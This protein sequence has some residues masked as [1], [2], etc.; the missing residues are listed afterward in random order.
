M[1]KLVLVSALTLGSFA[2]FAATP[3]IFH[4]GIAEDIYMVQEEY[5]EIEVAEV[6]QAITDALAADFPGAEISKAYKNE[7]SEYKLEVT[8]GEE[9][10]TLYANESGEWI[11]K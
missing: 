5:Q 7:A 1:K 4:D 6:P 11:Q 10:S 9:T 2:S 8:V 3:V